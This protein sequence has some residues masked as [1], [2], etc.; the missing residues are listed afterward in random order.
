MENFILKITDLVQ[1]KLGADY[2]ISMQKN[3]KNN[4]VLLH[5]LIIQNKSTN[6]TPS[7]YLDNLYQTYL[8]GNS[9]ECIAEEIIHIYQM[10]KPS[11]PF[12]ASSFLD[13]ENAKEHIVFQLINT[14]KNKDFL[15]DI[16]HVEYLDL[17]IIFKFLASSQFGTGFITIHNEHLKHWNITTKELYTLAVYST[18]RL[19][20]A[21]VESLADI[22]KSLG[23]T[24]ADNEQC[25]DDCIM[26]VL[27][28]S[29]RENGSGVLLYSKVLE[30]FAEEIGKD[31]YI[32]PSSIHECILIPAIEGI[33]SDDL[34]DMVHTVNATELSPIDFLSNNI[35]YYS[36][37][38]K[39]LELISA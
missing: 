13:F 7:I 38:T 19:L 17:S 8:K 2:K 25:E 39:K 21:Q 15:L 27:S 35:Y 11:H 16:P 28:N 3:L 31:L 29:R 36:R 33:K 34:R 9:L 23:V 14:E 18:P 26:Y 37:I 6:I 20:P 12:D 22:V 4:D 5:A 1:K 30:L 24:L 32:L 10:N